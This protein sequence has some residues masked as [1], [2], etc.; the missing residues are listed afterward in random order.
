MLKQPE[1]LSVCHLQSKCRF[2]R[3][4]N[5][6]SYFWW[7]LESDC[8][9]FKGQIAEDEAYIPLLSNSHNFK[10]VSLKFEDSEAAFGF[11]AVV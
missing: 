5:L 4:Q 7:F 1:N 11:E 2:T 6:I 10:N 3:V 9:K 8:L